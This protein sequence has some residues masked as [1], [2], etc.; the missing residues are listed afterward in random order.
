MKL[1]PNSYLDWDPDKGGKLCTPS[2]CLEIPKEGPEPGESISEEEPKQIEYHGVEWALN[3]AY[4]IAKFWSGKDYG[5]EFA[6]AFKR[7]LKKMLAK[8]EE[9]ENK[10]VKGV[11]SWLGIKPTVADVTPI[12]FGEDIVNTYVE[13]RNKLGEN[14]LAKFIIDRDAIPFAILFEYEYGWNPLSMRYVNVEMRG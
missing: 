12:N 6:E 8:R 10:I 13:L 3:T 2:G 7:A 5:D 9:W 14:E 1:G 4:G 11:Y